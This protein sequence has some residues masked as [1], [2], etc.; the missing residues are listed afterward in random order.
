M[1]CSCCGEERPSLAGLQCHDD[2]KVCTN[3]VG[4]LKGQLGMMDVTP[5]LPVLD[6]AVSVAF[7]EAA[8]FDVH[9]YR[10]DNEDGGYAF[11]HYEEQSVFDLGLEPS[12]VGA[13][14]FITVP[15]S[16]EWHAR[17][18]QL[19]YDVTTLRDEPWGMREFALTDPS[20]NRLRFGHGLDN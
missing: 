5:I 16:D 2:I 1:K 3:C 4:W 18:T 12:T 17:F 6:M 11:V 8:G 13:G 9:V 10:D 20:G 14:C 7:Y 15:R 19:G